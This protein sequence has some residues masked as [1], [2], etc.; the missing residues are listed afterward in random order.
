MAVQRKTSGSDKPKQ[1]PAT[2]P[3]ARENQLIMLAYDLAERQLRDG[4]AS[5]QIITQLLKSG[6][7]KDQ[8][9]KQKLRT[10]A[11]LAQARVENMSRSEETNEIAQRAI[12][13]MR[14]Y[15]GEDSDFEGNDD[16]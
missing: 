15:K 1:P 10:E 11:I 8:L 3:E 16:Y 13:A 7:V 2:T 14:S 5:S 12:D 6:T 4:S 9:E